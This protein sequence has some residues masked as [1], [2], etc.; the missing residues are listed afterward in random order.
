MYSTLIIQLHLGIS[1]CMFYLTIKQ[2]SMLRWGTT[3][4]SANRHSLFTHS[5]SLSHE[6]LISVW[7]SDLADQQ[8]KNKLLIIAAFLISIWIW[9]AN[10]LTISTPFKSPS[11]MLRMAYR[12]VK[13]TPRSLSAFPTRILMIC[14]TRRIAKRFGTTLVENSLLAKCVGNPQETR[15]KSVYTA[16]KSV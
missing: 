12:D 14:N 1:R 5:C 3:N 13:T 2:K 11:W 4:W 16:D 10:R 8:A 6:I 9:I 15:I 7:K